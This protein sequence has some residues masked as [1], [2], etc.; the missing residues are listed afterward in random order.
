MSS[1]SL[2][3]HIC[4][5]CTSVLYF[6]VRKVYVALNAIISTPAVSCVIRKLK[7]D[8]GFILT[9]SHNPGGINADF[10]IKFNTSNGGS[11]EFKIPQH[12]QIL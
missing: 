11:K 12:V 5:V 10:G 7:L 9:A 6:Q 8:G 2:I 4:S 3:S 1:A